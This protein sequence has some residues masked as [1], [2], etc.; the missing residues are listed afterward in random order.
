MEAISSMTTEPLVT[1]VVVPRER[2]SCTRESLESIYANTET[3]F[4]LIY[5]DGN[6][7]AKVRQ[8]LEEQSQERGFQ[9]IRTDYYLSPNEARNIGWRAVD[10]KYLVFADNDVVVAPGWLKKLVECAEETNATVVGP[11]MCQE[12][13]VHEIVHV[14]GGDARIWVDKTG[15]RRLREKIYFQGKRVEEIRSKLSRSLTEMVEFHCML[16]RRSIFDQLGSLDEALLNTREHLDFCMLVREAGGTVYLEPDSLVTYVPGPPLEW[17][18]LHFYMLRWSDEWELLSLKR[19][20][21]KWNVVEDGNFKTRYKRRGWR[22]YSII[23]EPFAYQLTFGIGSRFLARVMG[24]LDHLFLNPYLTARYAKMYAKRQPQ[25][26]A[27][28]SYQSS[29][30]VSSRG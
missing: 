17:T 11:L 26:D 13:P 27:G 8:Y 4:K 3:P 1:I 12:K 18:D 14:A 10:T 21:E 24:K 29:S 2:F 22:R 15:K 7:P 20:Q 28:M 9:L 6:S 16:V 25:L 5:V 23:F 19:L 30:T